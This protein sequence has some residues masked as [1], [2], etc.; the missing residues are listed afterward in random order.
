MARTKE[1]DLKRTAKN[2]RLK[3]AEIISRTQS[4]HIGPSFSCVEMLVALYYEVMNIS[5]DTLIENYNSQLNNHDIFLVF[6]PTTVI[7]D[8]LHL[9]KPV[10]ILS[11]KGMDTKKWDWTKSLQREV[12]D[13]LRRNPLVRVID[14][15]EGFSELV[16]KMTKYHKFDSVRLNTLYS[17]KIYQELIS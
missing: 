16:K 9:K 8:I 5:K 3:I 1:E 14:S 7:F 4:P 12:L 6:G 13:E 2:I 11:I 15:L 17:Q 10:I